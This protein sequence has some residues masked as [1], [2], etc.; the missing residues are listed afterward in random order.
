MAKTVL[1]FSTYV[2]EIPLAAGGLM[3][4]HARAGDRVV[5]VA[6]C[7][8]GWPSR[9]VY[10]EVTRENRWGRFQTEQNWER[11]VA[12]REID[13]LCRIIGIER[14]ITWNYAGDSDQ[15]FAMDVV[16]KTTDVIN[17]IEPDIVVTHWP[18]ADYTD[19]TGAGTAVLRCLC[20]RRLKKIPQVYFSETLTGRHTLLFAPNT[21]VDITDSIQ[22]KKEACGAIWEGKNIDYFFN[23]FALPIAQ[24]R[25][26]ECGVHFAEAY[27]ALHGSFGREK[28]PGIGALPGARPMTMHRTVKCLEQRELAEG[29][30][31]RSYGGPDGTID[32]EAAQKVYGV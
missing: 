30:Q 32:S 23:P 3:I 24:F 5:V 16:D 1:A 29:V 17:E 31:P 2:D 7:Y 18:I 19:F 11:T 10:P 26:R 27:A 28:R 15:L 22:A 21:Y 20:E 6:M 25:G 14:V 4:N 13:D 8:P 9:V 12:R